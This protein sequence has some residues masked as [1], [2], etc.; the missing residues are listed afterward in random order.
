MSEYT[1]L[2]WAKPPVQL[3][4]EAHEK[5]MGQG[6]TLLEQA[7]A[8]TQALANFQTTAL[9][10]NVDFNFTE[11]LTPFV[12]PTSPT[13]NPLDYRV[14]AP[15]APGLPPSFDAREPQFGVLPEFDAQAPVLAFGAKP[16]A[17]NV[18]MPIAP[19]RPFMPAMPEPPDWS[20]PEEVTLLGLNLPQMPN[21]QL[22]TFTSQRPNLPAFNLQD[23][24]GAFDPET[25]VSALM[26]KIENRVSTWMQGQEAL[27]AAIEQALFG[28]GRARI[29]VE[30]QASEQQVFDDFGTRGFSAP[31]GL[32]TS[33]LDAVRQD[34]Q[35]KKAEF[36][37][38]AM[39]KSFDEALANMRL[40]VQSGIQWEGVKINLHLEMQRLELQSVSYLRDTSIALLNA[41]VAYFNAEMSGYQVDGQLFETRL[42][43]EL[44][45][46]DLLRAQIEAEKL[47]GDLN[48]QTVRMYQAQ[49][50]A[51][52]TM[53]QFY[54]ERV[55]A[56]KVQMDA[57]K[58]PIEI[59]EAEVRAFETVWSAHA[60][61]WDG[62][63]AGVEGET[64]KAELYKV[65][66]DAFASRTDGVVK[67]GGLQMDKE[68]L[69]I[70]QHGQTL[71]QFRAQ[72]QRVDQLV[73][74]EESRLS[75]VS[76]RDRAAADI[77][78]ARADVEQAASAAAD[79]QFQSGLAAA[80]ANVD[81]QLEE[82]RIRSSENVQLQGLVLEALRAIATIFSQ[83]TAST[84]SAVN[85]SASVGAS[86]SSSR[87]R[88]V[89]WS[90]EAPDFNGTE[91]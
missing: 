34:A 63:R 54:G 30:R 90:G 21:V 32:L 60:K 80:R 18:A 89:G 57:Q 1:P 52:R 26:G 91:V 85:Y 15:D 77:Y 14:S 40:A 65:M 42:K 20:A 44:A 36:N 78:R 68:R 73:K 41:R 62:Y 16:T 43:A 29:E 82:A 6:N 70:E 48:E 53:A 5:F 39:L 3:V 59:F 79:R 75:A 88:S 51:V 86:E 11:Q 33:R 84:M 9:G 69:R 17:P 50:E 22:P 8:H 4:G 55:N 37:R 74:L 66:A 81:V 2:T 61:E 47:K 76:Q 10:F 28:R 23:N 56:V 87:S 83:L 49:W 27:P 13:L 24:F 64:A 58:V 46:L 19:A 35:N 25:Y 12:R 7:L 71:E 45:K 72:L 67:M 38:D 31:N